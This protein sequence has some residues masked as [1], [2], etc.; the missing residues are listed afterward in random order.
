[1]RNLAAPG[2]AFALGSAVLFGLSTPLAKV[3]G[4]MIPWVNRRFTRTR[5]RLYG[6][7]IRTIRICTTGIDIE[8]ST[9]RCSLTPLSL[10]FPLTFRR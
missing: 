10:T 8:V 1:M 7:S 4:P 9:L 5:M 6:T 3:L 2:P